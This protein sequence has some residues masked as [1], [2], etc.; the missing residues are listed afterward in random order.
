MKNERFRIAKDAHNLRV[1]PWRE[2]IG[3]ESVEDGAT[4][5][6]LVLWMAHG[7]GQPELA[8]KIVRLLNEDAEKS[9]TRT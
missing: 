6:A 3:I 5:P 9:A 4:I 7:Y 8:E 2:A 1:V